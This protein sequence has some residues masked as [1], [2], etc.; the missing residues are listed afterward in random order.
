MIDPAVT[1]P[2]FQQALDEGSISA[3]CSKTDP[4][5]FMAV[6]QI[7]KVVRF[8][9]FRKEKK[10]VIGIC[11]VVHTGFHYGV[12]CFDLGYAVSERFRR[13]GRGAELVGAAVKDHIAGMARAGVNSLYIQ[14]VVGIDNVAS[15]RIAERHLGAER[16]EITDSVSGLPAFRYV[17]AVG[18]ES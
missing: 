9:Y 6:D 17:L 14:A 11:M 1:L 12:I 3:K 4:R 10:K 18:T 16:E 2:S 13:Q 15:Q 5:L 8:T 7:G